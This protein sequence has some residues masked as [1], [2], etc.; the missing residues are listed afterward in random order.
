MNGFKCYKF[1][2]ICSPPRGLVD[3]NDLFRDVDLKKRSQI[4]ITTNTTETWQRKLSRIKQ[5]DTGN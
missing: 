1:G 2:E 4:A 5:C 3:F